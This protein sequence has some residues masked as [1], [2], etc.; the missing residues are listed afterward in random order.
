[1]RTRIA[2]I[3][4]CALLAAC[5]AAPSA[6]LTP[7]STSPTPTAPLAWQTYSNPQWGLTLSYPSDWQLTE[8]P[9]DAQTLPALLLQYPGADLIL[10]YHRSDLS[11]HYEFPRGAGQLEP[12]GSAS[13]FN[14]N[15][16]RQVLVNNDQPMAVYYGG[17]AEISAGPWSLAAALISQGDP[18][19][20][21]VQAQADEILATIALIPMAATPTP[22]P[23]PPTPPPPVPL[24]A[25]QDIQMSAGFCFDLDAGRL[26]SSNAACDFLLRTNPA[27]EANTIL[28]VPVSPARFTAQP[29]G[30]AACSPDLPDLSTAARILTTAD[31]PGISLCYQTQSGYVG[32]MV[33]RQL[34]YETLTFDYQTSEALG[35]TPASTELAVEFLGDVTI[36]DYTRITPGE[37]FT[38][39]WQFKNTGSTAWTTQFALVF[40]SGAQMDAQ[41]VIP[42]GSEV[43]P[44]QM[45]NLSATL[46]APEQPG[47]YVGYWMLQDAAGQRFGLGQYTNEPFYVIIQSAEPQP[48]MTATPPLISG[49]LRIMDAALTAEP[50]TYSG[51]CPASV[52]FTGRITTDGLG[53]FTY[54][55]EAG[56]STPGFAFT[57]PPSEAVSV[58]TGGM[59]SLDVSFELTFTDSVSGWARLKVIGPKNTVQTLDI[60]LRITCR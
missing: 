40:V 53:T 28:F 21:V 57:L 15:I 58:I 41:P 23:L 14:Q 52:A 8:Q 46:V 26:M 42:L 1:M 49:N 35:A 39:T 20:P 7:A 12:V 38:K 6:A 31:L 29:A 9:G 17:G 25:G 43:P 10:Y 18:L 55:L 19:S 30:Q 48:D 44:G 59:Q 32:Q 33:L 4:F 3:L 34:N 36:P 50:T 45:V 56:S 51:A 54:Q 5:T 11:G 37:A 22:S 13:L 27:L 60:P 2:L 47:T 24:S 16:A